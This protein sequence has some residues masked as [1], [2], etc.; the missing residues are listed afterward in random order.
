MSDNKHTGLIF[1]TKENRKKIAMHFMK[2]GKS[3]PY[4]AEF[5]EEMKGVNPSVHAGSFKP[6]HKRNTHDQ[7]DPETPPVV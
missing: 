5:A 1:M 6:G 3:H 4:I 2:L 7:K